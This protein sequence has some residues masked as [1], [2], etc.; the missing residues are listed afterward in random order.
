VVPAKKY[1]VFLKKQ[2]PN[3]LNGQEKRQGDEA[4]A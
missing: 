2:F 3:L 1:G 4:I